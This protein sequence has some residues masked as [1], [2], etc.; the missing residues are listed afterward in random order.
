[1][2]VFLAAAKKSSP[3]IL[4]LKSSSTNL[5]FLLSG[6]GRKSGRFKKTLT[7]DHMSYSFAKYNMAAL[8][9]QYVLSYV[10]GLGNIPGNGRLA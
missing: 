2:T 6:H 8:Y 3:L 9:V 4:S 7:L 10:L 1:M 5:I